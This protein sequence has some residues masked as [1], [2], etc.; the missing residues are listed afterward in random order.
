MTITL[1]V[2]PAIIREFKARA[3][4]AFPKETWALMLGTIAGDHAHVDE[5]YWPD[6]VDRF[7]T[8]CQVSEQP[9]WFAEA[10]EQAKESDLVICGRLHSHPYE[11]DEAD[12]LVTD[13]AQSEGDL[14]SPGS[15]YLIS[16]VC[17]VQELKAKRLRASMRFWGP[18]VSVK[19]KKRG[20]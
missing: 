9:H 6:D 13:R 5:L 18:T 17:V 3:K 11:R 14:D 4:T 19:L 10:Q 2:P 15:R 8:N 1:T 16:G 12:F 20:V 7:A